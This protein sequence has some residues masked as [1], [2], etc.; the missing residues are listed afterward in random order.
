MV[1]YQKLEGSLFEYCYNIKVKYGISYQEQFKL[2]SKQDKKIFLED[3]KRYSNA[4][5]THLTYLTMT[6]ELIMNEI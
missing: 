6:P 2:L 1:K 4:A 3:R 5:K